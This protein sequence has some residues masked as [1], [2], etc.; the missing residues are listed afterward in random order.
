MQSRIR[1][2]RHQTSETGSVTS[3]RDGPE[4][5]RILRNLE[6]EDEEE[7]HKWLESWMMIDAAE[8]HGFKF[9]LRQ[10]IF[11]WKFK[12]ISS[13]ELCCLVQLLKVQNNS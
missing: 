9:H 6:K 1:H 4:L 5:G 10:L 12:M 8:S 2:R 13:D 11:L 7:N 3:E